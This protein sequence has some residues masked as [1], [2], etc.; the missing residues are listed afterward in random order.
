MPRWLARLEMSAMTSAFED[1]CPE[2]DR[3]EEAQA[4]PKGNPGPERLD[5]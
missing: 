1:D 3:A 5:E 2:R 4:D